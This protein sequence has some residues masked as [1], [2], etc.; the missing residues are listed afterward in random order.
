MRVVD[1]AKTIAP[2]M[3]HKIIGVRPGE[4]IHEQMIGADDSDFTYEYSNYYKILPQINDW[5]KDKLRIKNGKKV[6]DE[7]VYSSNNN[8]DWM[9]EIDLKKWIDN[10]KDYIGNF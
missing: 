1:I 8:L 3:K 4:K 9:T 6:P 7:F 5:S 10:N 2:N